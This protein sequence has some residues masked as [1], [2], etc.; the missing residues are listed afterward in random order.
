MVVPASL[1]FIYIF[2]L[3][4]LTVNRRGNTAL[5]EA[6]LLGSVGKPGVD[7]LLSLG[8]SSKV[9]NSRD[10]T[11]YDLAIKGGE[12]TIISMFAST[13]GQGMLDKL[14]KQSSR[15]QVERF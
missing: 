15:P 11:A 8:A 5:H 1:L 3:L 4:L 6:V 12:E 2:F 14:M 9:K 7:E 10:E 13:A